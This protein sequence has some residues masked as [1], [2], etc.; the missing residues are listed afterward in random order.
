MAGRE[1]H[2]RVAVRWTGNTGS[3]TEHYRSYSRSHEIACPA[4]PDK[5][6]IPG[7]SDPAFRG[8]L[9]RWNPEEL[10]VAALSA[11]HKLWYLHLCAA[12]GIVVESYVDEAEGVM[13]ESDDGSGRFTSVTL[14]PRVSITRARPRRHTASTTKP[15]PVSSRTQLTCRCA[16]KRRS[17]RP[18]DRLSNRHRV[19]SGLG[20]GLNA[21]V[22]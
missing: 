3:G 17:V 14:R 12:A 6:V 9:N 4:A 16:L 13:M 11:C 18:I 21:R 22:Q 10:F 7:S 19:L 8:D 20:L 5:P 1:H 15:T 2:Y